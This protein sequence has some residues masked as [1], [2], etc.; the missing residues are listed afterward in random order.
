MIISL[1][2]LSFVS[3]GC[4]SRTEVEDLAIAS[5]IGI[6]KVEQDD[7][8]EILFS[9]LVD[10]PEHTGGGGAGES[11]GG[12][13][14]Q[15]QGWVNFGQGNSLDDAKRNLFTTTAKRLF[16]G[17]SRVI[18]LG[19]EKAKEGVGDI[20][21]YLA[22]DKGIRMRNWLLVTSAGTAFET[23]S[24]H[25]ELTNIFSEEVNELLTLSVPRVS[26][27]YAVDLKNFLVD[28]TTSGKEAVLPLLEIR[29]V[30]SDES[31]DNQEGNQ[32]PSQKNVRLKGLA[33]FKG[34]KMIGEL[35]DT[36]TKGFLWIMGKAQSGTLTFQVENSGTKKPVQVTVEMTRANSKI[37]TKIVRG[38]PVVIVKIDTEGNITEFS[39]NNAASKPEDIALVDRG[40]G[41]AVKK[42][43]IMVLNK[44]Q[45]NFK[46]D[47][48]GFGTYFHRQQL[49]YWKQNNLEESWPEV[50]PEVEVR[51]EVKAN[52]RR[53]GLTAD[54]ITIK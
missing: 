12:S 48:F 38:K 26:K 47:I 6:D 54:G 37:E 3:S 44:C 32:S 9:V 10:K 53:T 8:G 51:V 20:I 11:G 24:V 49:K 45:K 42:Q 18:I 7:H 43:V 4:W 22:R 16:L 19:E 25:P 1:L 40:Y 33:V 14:G 29:K 52:V 17:H 34:D 23:F 41:E 35:G 2:L 5:A 31:P 13:G 46:S 27:S 30:L 21:D 36:E 50:F 28:L 15:M 39:Q